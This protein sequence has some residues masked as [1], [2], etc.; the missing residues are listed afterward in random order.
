MFSRPRKP[1]VDVRVRLVQEAR[2][3]LDPELDAPAGAWRRVQ[4][5]IPQSPE[6]FIGIDRVPERLGLNRT[7]K[8]PLYP[9]GAQITL[10]LLP[11]QFLTGASGINTANV[12]MIIEFFGGE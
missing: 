8:L 11:H 2:V 10:A 7:Y 4:I 3:F 9:P 12:S 6:V 5:L 1:T